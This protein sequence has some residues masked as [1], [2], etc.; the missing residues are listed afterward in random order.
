M[1]RWLVGRGW[2]GHALCAAGTWWA[3]H[4]VRSGTGEIPLGTDSERGSVSRQCSFH[5]GGEIRSRTIF[6]RRCSARDVQ[7]G[8]VECTERVVRVGGEAG[9]DQE[10]SGVALERF[11][12]LLQQ[13]EE[14]FRAKEGIHGEHTTETKNWVKTVNKTEGR[15]RGNCCWS[16]LL[17]HFTRSQGS[18]ERG[19]KEFTKRESLISNRVT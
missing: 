18:T 9:E 15:R 5:K 12:P 3:G 16:V 6:G 14:V 8:V 19:D 1:R 10:Q 7:A 17:S 2:L 13:E 4:W 11:L